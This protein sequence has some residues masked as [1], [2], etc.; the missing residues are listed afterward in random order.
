MHLCVSQTLPEEKGVSLW[1]HKDRALKWVILAELSLSPSL[2]V[3]QGDGVASC[4]LISSKY[5][6]SLPLLSTSR[7]LLFSSFHFLSWSLSLSVSLS[8]SLSL[9][10]NLSFSIT[11]SLCLCLSSTLSHS[12]YPPYSPFLSTILPIFSPLFLPK[13]FCSL[14]PSV[15]LSLFSNPSF[16]ALF[17][18]VWIRTSFRWV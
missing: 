10:L 7:S 12:F 14:I 18:P 13:T 11:R 4:P 2:C 15:P 9:L 17:Q 16:L 3:C 8:R 6:I 5:H 1:W